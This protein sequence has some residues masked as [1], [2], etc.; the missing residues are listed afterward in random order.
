MDVIV[1]GVGAVGSV[2]GDLLAIVI[3]V[4]NQRHDDHGC[5]QQHNE[6]TRDSGNNFYCFLHVM[7]SLNW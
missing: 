7:A 2:A 5:D 3:R 6:R 1:V 4:N